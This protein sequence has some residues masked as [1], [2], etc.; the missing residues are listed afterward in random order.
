MKSLTTII[1]VSL[2]LAAGTAFAQ[3]PTKTPSPPAA[4]RPAMDHSKMGMAGMSDADREKMAAAQFAK[5]DTNKDGSLSKAEFAASFS[6][7]GMQH[8]QMDHSRM[9][10]AGMKSAD[11]QKMAAAQFAKLDANKDGKLV[12]AEIPADHP[13]S[14]HFSMLDTNNDGS[15]SKAEFDQHHGM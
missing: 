5:L 15:I 8:G 11:H 3:Q 9:G 14:A 7:T 10:M 4:T 1:A 2:T 12:K 13:L 6:M